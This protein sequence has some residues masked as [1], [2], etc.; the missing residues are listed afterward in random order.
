[1]TER[2]RTYARVVTAG[3]VSAFFLFILLFLYRNIE[4]HIELK[5]KY[6]E[7]EYKRIRL[8]LEILSSSISPET[9]RNQVA[10]YL[11]EKSAG[12]LSPQDCVLVSGTILDAKA[13]YGFPASLCVA[14]LYV[15]SGFDPSAVSQMNAHGIAQV[16]PSTARPYSRLFHLREGVRT[17]DMLK[18]PDLCARVGFAYL[19][20][21]VDSFRITP[22]VFKTRPHFPAGVAP[23]LYCA[24]YA[25]NCGEGRAR[26]LLSTGEYT[27]RFADLVFSTQEKVRVEGLFE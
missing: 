2:F 8:Q 12:R 24:V 7:Q 3:V 9:L 27:N 13:L 23:E 4:K 15:E 6:R 5:E 22:P 19:A 14:L 10:K 25:Y 16:L 21:L 26:E 20:D 18:E 11:M 17:E 1:M